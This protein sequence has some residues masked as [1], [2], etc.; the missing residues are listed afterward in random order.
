MLT[1]EQIQVYANIDRR[2]VIYGE[3]EFAAG[4]IALGTE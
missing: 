1:K 3:N 2:G 4:L